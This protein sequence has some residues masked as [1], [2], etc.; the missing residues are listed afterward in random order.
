MLSIKKHG[1]IYFAM[2]EAL[3]SLSKH[4]VPKYI[5][6]FQGKNILIFL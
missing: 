6:C 4:G 3:W 2:S 1:E 5:E